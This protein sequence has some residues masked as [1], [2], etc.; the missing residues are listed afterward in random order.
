MRSATGRFRRR[1]MGLSEL[2]VDL[3]CV[4]GRTVLARAKDAGGSIACG[5]GKSVAVPTLSQLRR[6][7]G[8]DAY[9]TNPAEAIR[10]A[11]RQGINPAGDKCLICGSPTAVF[12]TCDAICETS[13]L[14]RVAGTESTDIPRL[15]SFLILPW[16]LSFL[17]WR[18]SQP[19]EAEIRGHDIEVT[20]SLPV[21]DPCATTTGNVTRPS[22]A[23][24]IMANVPLYRELLEYYPNLTLRIERP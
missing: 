4:C 2:Q 7:A 21:C 8:V 9:V 3:T 23:K 13:Q 5:C 22:V 10:K 12:Y 18:R 1:N 20:F 14:K 24:Q 19:A 11:Q 15:L 17:M 16:I 6:L